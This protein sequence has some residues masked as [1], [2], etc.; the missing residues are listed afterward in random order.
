M[1]SL[2][3]SLNKLIEI[4]T[5]DKIKMFDDIDMLDKNIKAVEKMT[6]VTHKKMLN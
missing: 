2:K 6:A 3:E 1:T 5:I 4:V